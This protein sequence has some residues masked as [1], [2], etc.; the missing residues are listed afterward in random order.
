VLVVV[1]VLVLSS[2]VLVLVLV[3][4][5]NAERRHTD[6]LCPRRTPQVTGSVAA[7]GRERV[8]QK[9]AKSI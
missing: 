3:I 5:L 7:R 6:T 2:I 8:K 4:D 1:L 9:G